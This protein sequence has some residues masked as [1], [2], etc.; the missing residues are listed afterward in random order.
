[1]YE[2]V[3]VDSVSGTVSTEPI[4]VIG[5]CNVVNEKICQPRFNLNVPLDIVCAVVSDTFFNDIF[6]DLYVQSRAAIFR[7]PHVRADENAITEV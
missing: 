7:W 3:A 6:T 2:N 4:S 5:S 1:M